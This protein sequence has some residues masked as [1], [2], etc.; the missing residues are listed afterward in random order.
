MN[1]SP[2]L[3]TEVPPAVVTVMST[4]PEPDG[5]VAV[6]CVLE[7]AVILPPLPPKL[8]PVA[9]DRLVPVIVTE[10]P[11]PAGP[12]LGEISRTIGAATE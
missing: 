10:V 9:F 7:S 12:L 4:V 8:T 3:V 2:L 11:P 5:L 6:I 1:L